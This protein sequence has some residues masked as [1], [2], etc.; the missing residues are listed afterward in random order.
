[1]HLPDGSVN[2]P[3]TQKH[4]KDCM[5]IS[6]KRLAMWQQ[7]SAEECRNDFMVAQVRKSRV[8]RKAGARQGWKK[9]SIASSE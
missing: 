9:R 2:R 6:R 1:M 8:V 3:F 4:L 5:R 7:K